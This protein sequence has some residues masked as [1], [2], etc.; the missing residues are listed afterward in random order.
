[1]ARQSLREEI[2]AA[3]QKDVRTSATCAKP[4]VPW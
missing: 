2:V 3:A 1:M 4:P